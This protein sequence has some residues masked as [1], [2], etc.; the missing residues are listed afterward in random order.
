MTFNNDKDIYELLNDVEFD[1]SDEAEMPMDDIEKQ[2]LKKRVKSS[3]GK[4][5]KKKGW[6]RKQKVTAAMIAFI[7]LG[8][9]ISPK[10]QEV[11]ASIKNKLFFNPGAGL[12]SSTEET[13]V[14]KEPMTIKKENEEIMIKS[15]MAKGKSIEVGIWVNR[16]Y[17]INLTKEE[18][19]NRPKD[20][21]YIKTPEEEM[22]KSTS[23]A[24]GGGG[25]Y[26]FIN[27]FFETKELLKEFTL[28]FNGYEEEI[29]LI[30]AEEKNSYDEVGGNNTDK[31]LLIGANKYHLQGNTYIA[32]WSDE[33]TKQN[34][35]NYIGYNREKI[36]VLGQDSGKIYEM[37]PAPFDGSGKEFYVGKDVKEPLKITISEVDMD[38]RL[39]NPVKFKLPI[40]KKGETIDISEEVF[41]EDLNEKV[42]V[43]SIAGTEEGIEITA[44]AAKYRKKDSTISIMSMGRR[45][46]GIG[47]SPEDTEIKMGV[48]YENLSIKEKLT[49]KLDVEIVNITIIRQGN[50]NFT[51]K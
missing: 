25:E 49:N 1:I 50:W 18:Y 44:D 28:V 48:D 34:G 20:E 2:K 11:I 46:W 10:G 45:G 14:L 30:K 8:T 16:A 22:I 47:A 29:K 39:K 24:Q 17:N 6:S 40:P 32:F 33:E 13:Y 38:Y 4:G 41:I 15:V 26:T 9:I 31:N 7:I 21:V 35:A 5:I 27:T 51:V 43:K 36:K 19:H 23:A 42:F 3:I 37:K 12:V